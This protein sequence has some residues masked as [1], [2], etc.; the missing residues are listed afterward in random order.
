M[1]GE[2]A[3]VVVDLIGEGGDGILGDQVGGGFHNDAYVVGCEVAREGK[4][5][6]VDR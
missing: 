6:V 2:S 1:F 5:P 4:G 3:V